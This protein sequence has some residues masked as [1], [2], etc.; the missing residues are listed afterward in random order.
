MIKRV[1]VEDIRCVVRGKKLVVFGFGRAGKMVTKIISNLYG[2]INYCFCDNDIAKQNPNLKVYSIVDTI[3]D[4]S[5]YLITFVNDNKG[6]IESAINCL[7]SWEIPDDRIFLV[8]YESYK[9]RLHSID[10]LK[11]YINKKLESRI[12]TSTD[13][14]DR[15]VFVSA[16]YDGNMRKCGGPAAVLMM[17]DRLLKGNADNIEMLFPISPEPEKKDVIDYA[18]PIVYSISLAVGIGLKQAGLYGDNCLF[19]SNDMWD[20]LGLFLAGKKYCLIHHAQG[21]IVC[22]LLM[23]GNNLSAAEIDY[24]K[25]LEKMVIENAIQ[26]RFPSRGAESYFRATYGSEIKF[27][28]Q[29]PLYNTIYDFPDIKRISNIEKKDEVTTF[30]SVGQFT[31]LK[32]MDRIP[33]FLETY[34]RKTGYKIRWIAVADGVLKDEI[35]ESLEN[36]KST[37][38]N[39]FE[40]QLLSPQYTHGEMYYLFSISDV[41]IMLHRIS[42]FDFATLEAMYM[43]KAVILSKIEGNNE[44]NKAENVLLVNPD[45]YDWD[46]IIAYIS[47]RDDYGQLNKQVFHDY[48][49]QEPFRKAYLDFVK[50]M[51]K[52]D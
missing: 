5:V 42:I 38:Q 22:E 7:K 10:Y 11:L 44:F 15:I 43:G 3:S 4:D 14:F 40:F 24:L 36:I 27:K 37:F 51:L 20:A 41:Y 9:G 47:E 50:E 35:R 31:K 46:S 25:E 33:E 6:K 34:I 2:D 1:S 12:E 26:V 17:Q 13:S 48:F 23:W 45:N 29:K 52:N 16:Y 8:P 39:N 21:D 28:S 18:D 30:L 19:I 32:G 49:S